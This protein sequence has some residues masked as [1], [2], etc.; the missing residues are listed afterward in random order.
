MNLGDNVR[1]VSA[2]LGLLQALRGKKTMLSTVVAIASLAWGMFLPGQAPTE[3]QIMDVFEQGK[4]I[5]DTAQHQVLPS[6]VSLAAEMVALVGMIAAFFFGAA[7]QNRVAI[8]MRVIGELS[9]KF[10]DINDLHDPA[11]VQKLKGENVPEN[12]PAI[13]ATPVQPAA[14]S[15]PPYR[16]RKAS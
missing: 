10:I 8:A 3:G 7:A 6:V 2:V 4:E 14:V 15:S 1:K 11:L 16:G 12:P 5:V 9:G 13:K